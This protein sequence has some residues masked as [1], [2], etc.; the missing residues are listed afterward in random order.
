MRA[1]VFGSNGGLGLRIVNQ[2][3]DAGHQVVAVAR[4]PEKLSTNHADVEKVAVPDLTN[5]QAIES[6][7]GK[8]IGTI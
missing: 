5:S 2:L 1:L 6:L 8:G 4:S 3:C 7:L